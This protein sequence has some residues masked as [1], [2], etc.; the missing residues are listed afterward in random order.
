MSSPFLRALALSLL[1]A[2]L[3]LACASSP[4]LSKARSRR[5]RPP[6][7]A[8]KTRSCPPSRARRPRRPRRRP[9]QT[10][11]ADTASAAGSRSADVELG[12]KGFGFV[13]EPSRSPEKIRP[14]SPA[15]A[16][17]SA[18]GL[19]AGFADDNK[20]FNYFVNFLAEYGGEVPHLPI[21][22]EERIVLKVTDSAG[23]PVPNADVR[24]SADGAL[25]AAGRTYADGTFLFFPSE[26][27]P[28]I[29][30]VHRPR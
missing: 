4:G 18:S 13:E 1:A 5:P 29:D 10:A 25:L 3:L 12:E 7:N 20:Q 24:V 15:A 19:Q 30:I 21:P 6:R 14:E 28:S 8:R 22:V 11:E 17:P 16:A 9:G 23:K 26:H 27:P 2:G